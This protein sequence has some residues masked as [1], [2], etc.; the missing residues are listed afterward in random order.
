MPARPSRVPVSRKVSMLSKLQWCLQAAAHRSHP[1]LP[2]PV[3][4]PVCRLDRV[5]NCSQQ[6]KGPW[7]P[8]LV[9]LEDTRPVK[10]EVSVGSCAYQVSTGGRA[11]PSQAC[12]WGK[13]ASYSVATQPGLGPLAAQSQHYTRC[14]WQTRP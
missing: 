3:P 13:G 9:C 6:Q 2:L 1:L 10:M 11:G 5:I 12:G 7:L 14:A 8:F 4:A